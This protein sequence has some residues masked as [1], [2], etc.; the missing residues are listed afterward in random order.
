MTAE[1]LD[2]VTHHRGIAGT[3]KDS[4]RLKTRACPRTK[5]AGPKRLRKLEGCAASGRFPPSQRGRLLG[6]ADQASR[7]SDD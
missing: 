6:G 2:R 4:L 7:W 5:Q 1:L 3:G